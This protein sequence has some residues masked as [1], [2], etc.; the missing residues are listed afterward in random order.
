MI[1]LIPNDLRDERVYGRRNRLLIG[2]ILALL[3]TAVI[4]ATIMVGSLRFVGADE[5]NLKNSITANQAQVTTLEAKIKD[6]STI[7]S[8]LDTA[9]KLQDSS[10]IFSD[11][12]PSIGSLLPAGSVL[13]SLSLSGGNFDPLTL[14]IRMSSANLA[15]V[16]QR[17]LVDSE[18]FEAADIVSIA[19]GESDEQYGVTVALSA[20][21]TGS[22]EAK[23]KEAAAAEAKKK[24]AEEAAANQSGNQS[25]GN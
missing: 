20:S 4:V 12:I 14:N 1:N 15:P 7:S 10:I 13:T 16:L 9:N 21:F 19:S 8:R 3:L 18:L 11:L 25:G 5:A 22:A 6:L 2:Y 23:R 24:A 17:N